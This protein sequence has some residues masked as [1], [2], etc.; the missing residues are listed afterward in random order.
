M[1][2]RQVARDVENFEDS[3]QLTA[4]DIHEPDLYPDGPW[5]IRNIGFSTSDVEN[6]DGEP[7]KLINLRYEGFEPGPE[8]DPE[9]VEAGG[10]EGR[11]LWVRRYISMPA[12]KAKVDGTL[13]RF[14]NFV[15]MHGVD[16][17]G[18]NVEEMCKALK[19]TLLGATIGQR[20]YT[21]REGD[22]VND[23]TATDFTGVSD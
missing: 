8:V 20:S 16:T 14:V 2:K 15:A 1:A 22:T 5:T 6:R 3:M 7:Q 17:S 11:T 13:A 9:L 4:E 10:Y 21:N 12:A 23:N 18:R 19:G